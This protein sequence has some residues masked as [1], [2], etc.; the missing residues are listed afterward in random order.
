[1]RARIHHAVM[2]KLAIGLLAGSLTF[3]TGCG[4]Q[5]KDIAA[6]LPLSMPEPWRVEHTSSEERQGSSYQEVIVWSNAKPT[7]LGTLA[8]SVPLDLPAEAADLA[9]RRIEW[10]GASTVKSVTS[11]RDSTHSVTLIETSEGWYASVVQSTQ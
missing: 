8:S 4:D 9:L 5:K 2:S 10:S 7:L 6:K 11:I 1:M 3:I